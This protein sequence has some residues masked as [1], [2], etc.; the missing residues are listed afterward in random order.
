MHFK[1]T[2][3]EWGGPQ[4][5]TIHTGLVYSVWYATESLKGWEKYQEENNRLNIQG[6][7]S[8]LCEHCLR[9]L[10]SLHNRRSSTAP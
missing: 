10:C 2:C 1:H 3:A 9:D 5:L 6:I 7:I 4:R 8:W